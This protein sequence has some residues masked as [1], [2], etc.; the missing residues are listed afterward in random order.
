MYFCLRVDLDYVPWDTPDAKEFGHGEPA[1]LLRILELARNTGFKFHFFAS[2]RVLRAFPTNADAVLNEGHDL[3]WFCKHLDE[4]GARFEE[5]MAEFATLGHEPKGF[6]LREKWPEGV[7]PFDGMEKLKFIS[8]PNG[9]V[10]SQFKLFPVEGRSIRDIARTGVTARTWVDT[11][12][13]QVREAASRNI[14]IT[15]PVRPQVLARLDPKMVYLRELLDL[16]NAV[17]LPVRTLRDVMN[18]PR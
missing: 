18:T 12:K 1:M 7:M 9:K 17:G 4:P 10:P 6:S 13:A 2:N 16:A 8:A 14:G 15:F 3:D 5:A 11:T